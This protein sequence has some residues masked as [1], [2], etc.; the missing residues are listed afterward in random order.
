[1]NCYTV[2]PLHTDSGETYYQIVRIADAGHW[3]VIE[4]H[5]RRATADASCRRLNAWARRQA[6]LEGATR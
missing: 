1:M 2:R 5:A 3:T 4:T 6:E